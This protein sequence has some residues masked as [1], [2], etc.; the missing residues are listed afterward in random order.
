M[1][2]LPPADLALKVAVA[3]RSMAVEA[4]CRLEYLSQAGSGFLMMLEMGT[5]WGG[6]QREWDRGHVLYGR[7]QARCDR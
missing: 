4:H 6:G 7:H 2:S 3:I 1:M 5:W